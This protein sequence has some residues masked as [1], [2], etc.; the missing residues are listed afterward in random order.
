MY[1]RMT[2]PEQHEATLLSAAEKGR[3]QA[4]LLLYKSEIARLEK[5]WGLTIEPM[6][7]SG[8]S[9]LLCRVR[10]DTAFANATLTEEQTQYVLTGS[11]MP[12]TENFAQR[13]FLITA[14]VK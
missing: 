2:R 11:Q 6:T 5:K 13:L 8:S 1:E 12:T 10:W 9:M 3:W 14:C 4:S 7:L